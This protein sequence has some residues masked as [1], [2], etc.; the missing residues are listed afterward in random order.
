M[1]NLIYDKDYDYLMTRQEFLMRRSN[2]WD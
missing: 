1:N 2:K